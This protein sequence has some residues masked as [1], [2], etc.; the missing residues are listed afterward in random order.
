MAFNIPKKVHIGFQER[1]GTYSGKLGFVTYMKPDGSGLK[2]EG[3]W[4]SWRDNKIEPDVLDNV[5]TE[6]FVLNENGGGSK[7]YGHWERAEFVRVYHPNG[8][9]F[10]IS[11]D[12][13][14]FLIQECGIEKGKGIVGKCVFAWQD[15]GQKVILLPANSKEY[16]DNTSV[17]ELDYV[18]YTKKMKVGH[19]YQFRNGKE[20]VY[21]GKFKTNQFNSIYN[22]MIPWKENEVFY[23]KT[24]KYS[25]YASVNKTTIFQETSEPVNNFAELLELLQ[26]DWLFVPISEFVLS[27]VALNDSGSFSDNFIKL[28]DNKYCRVDL[29]RGKNVYEI[30]ETYSIKDELATYESSIYNQRRK[31]TLDKTF[32]YLYVKNIHGEIKNVEDMYFDRLETNLRDL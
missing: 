12:N 7:S 8:F 2:Q 13:L 30:L 17:V 14:L 4:N 19:G 23:S 15:N 9:E 1:T 27:D 31:I 3:S 6:G 28:D 24:G 26:H 25:K 20:V 21:M 29:E 5:P 10:E 32:N 22:G 11:F 18:P 16:L